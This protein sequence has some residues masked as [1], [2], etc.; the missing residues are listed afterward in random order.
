MSKGTVRKKIFAKGSRSSG[1]GDPTIPGRVA[2]LENNE[3]KIAYFTEI[4][5]QSGTITIPTGATI[6]LDQLPKGADALVSTKDAISGI[7]TGENPKTTLDEAVDVATFDASGNYTLTGNCSSY[8][9]CL[10]YW[11]SIKAVDYSSLNINNILEEQLQTPKVID[12][13]YANVVTETTAGNLVAGQFYRILNFP[14]TTAGIQLV[15]V[16]FK[17]VYNQGADLN[18]LEEKGTATTGAPTGFVELAVS[19]YAASIEIIEIY[20]Q[21]YNNKLMKTAGGTS[22]AIDVLKW[23]DGT[24]LLNA[25]IT[26]LTLNKL[27]ANPN[28]VIINST[29]ESDTLI[30]CNFFD[31]LEI[32][33]SYI[34]ANNILNCTDN[35]NAI[36]DCAVENNANIQI[37]YSG[38]LACDIGTSSIIGADG[39]VFV[40][41]INCS[42]GMNC[43]IVPDT[44]NAYNLT[45]CTWSNGK[46]HTILTDAYSKIWVGTHNNFSITLDIDTKIAGGF[47]DAPL[48]YG[49][50]YTTSGTSTPGT[51]T[52]LG[53]NIQSHD[54]QIINSDGTSVTFDN[55][56]GTISIAGGSSTLALSNIGDNAEL[57]DLT[58]LLGTVGVNK[59]SKY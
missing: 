34:G 30:E 44:D 11:L 43:Y 15:D 46:T 28:I 18:I 14:A 7:P 53:L 33:T 10:I 21:E 22:N 25:N 42:V 9:V 35:N 6:L 57:L 54:M 17:A 38:L 55:S 20:N 32:R 37:P 52:D 3:Y 56:G 1:G 2:N 23:N 4:N 36:T 29:I 49:I 40:S 51:I 26:N 41:M 13:D 19:W 59:H 8:P 12:L 45:L 27:P 50:L 31:G 16:T 5:S 58:T 24:F 39:F 48:G 47:F